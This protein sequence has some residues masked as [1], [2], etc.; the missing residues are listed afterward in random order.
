MLLDLTKKSKEY[1]SEQ[2][3]AV[4]GTVAPPSCFNLLARKTTRKG[5]DAIYTND[6]I[7]QKRHRPHSRGQKG[8]I[9]I[10]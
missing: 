7:L 9:I 8:R 2:T 6:A 5:N 3:P 4:T 10:E 1:C